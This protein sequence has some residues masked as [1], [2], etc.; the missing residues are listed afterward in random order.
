MGGWEP[1]FRNL[2]GYA[3]RQLPRQHGLPYLARTVNYLDEAPRLQ[4]FVHLGKR[5]PLSLPIP[6]ATPHTFPWQHPGQPSAEWL[7][8]LHA[9][10]RATQKWLQAGLNG[11]G[12]G[13]LLLTLPGWLFVALIVLPV[14]GLWL[15]R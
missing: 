10:G 13:L 6:M 11:F 2:P 5:N 3:L 14:M 12:W 9:T 8:A 1:S 15:H 4:V 7:A